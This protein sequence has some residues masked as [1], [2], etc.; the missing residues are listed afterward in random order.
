M[1]TGAAAQRVATALPDDPKLRR[2]L[3]ACSIGLELDDLSAAAAIRLSTKDK[4]EASDLLWRLKSSVCVWERG[5]GT[6]K[7]LA[8]VRKEAIA[9]FS[10]EIE[11]DSAAEIQRRMIDAAERRAA[12]ADISTQ[13]GLYARRRA[14]VEGAYLKLWTRTR[15]EQAGTELITLWNQENAGGQRAIA[16]AMDHLTLDFSEHQ[17]SAEVL[18]FR[19]MA[20]VDRDDRDRALGL[21][22]SVIAIAADIRTKALGLFTYGQIEADRSR[23]LDALGESGKLWTDAAHQERVRSAIESRS[24]QKAVR[25]STAN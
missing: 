25:E 6:W 19:G 10:H 4:P 23:A 12:H 11:P 1:S 20:A 17:S 7:L 16:R 21:F 3:V 8:K 18:L 15:R 13:A 2:A 22:R 14:I 24:A 9:E 5:D